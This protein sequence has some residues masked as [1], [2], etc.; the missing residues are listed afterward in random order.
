[1][2]RDVKR[3][4]APRYIR[5][6]EEFIASAQDNLEKERFN[7]AGFE[8][9]Q[10][11]INA[12][13]ALTSHFLGKRASADHRE[14]IRLHI[15]VVKVLNDSDYRKSLKDALEMRSEFG[16][17]GKQMVEK[18]ARRLIVSSIKFIAWVKNKIS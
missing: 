16:Y 18:D 15:D 10:S 8:A 9:T 13:D 11:M 12:N 7:A 4:D 5:Q 17:L 6:A 3:S 14:A 2:V 1:M